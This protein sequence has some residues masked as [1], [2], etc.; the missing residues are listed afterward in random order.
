MSSDRGI[1]PRRGGI[2]APRRFSSKKKSPPTSEQGPHRPEF[3][4]GDIVVSGIPRGRFYTIR[5]GSCQYVIGR[6][7]LRKV[8]RDSVSGMG[9]GRTTLWLFSS[10]YRFMR[11]AQKCPII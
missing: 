1:Y 6:E 11:T 7:V 10:P 2:V 4:A 8:Q 5:L 3:F 9:S